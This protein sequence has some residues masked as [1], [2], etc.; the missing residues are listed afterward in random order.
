MLNYQDSHNSRS[1]RRVR[2]GVR[3]GIA[4]AVALLV[5]VGVAWL[6][7]THT[8][9]RAAG[10]GPEQDESGVGLSSCTAEGYTSTTSVL[11][12]GTI[13]FHISSD[14][15]PLDIYIYREG[16]SKEL[17]T[18][19]N[20][21]PAQMFPCQNSQLGC[22]WPIAY[23]LQ[24][25]RDWRS[26]LYAAQLVGPGTVPGEH[27]E[28]M[29]FVVLEDMPGSTARILVQ[30][31]SNTWN[32]Y[33][34]RQGLSF[35]TTPRAMEIS[36]DRPYVRQPYGTGPYHWEVPVVRWLESHGYTAEYCTNVDLHYRPEMLDH[37]PMF[38]SLGHDEY[39]SKEM[40]DNLEAYIGRGGNVAFFSSNTCYWQVRLEDQ[41]RK[42]VCFKDDYQEDPL[43]GVD[44][45][46][47]THY[48]TGYPVNRP[49]NKLT[50]VSYHFG[51]IG[52]GGYRVYHHDHW[53]YEGTGLLDEDVFGEEGEG[54]QAREADGAR[55]RWSGG[56]P[57]PTGEDGTPLNFTILGLASK[58]G[59]GMMGVYQRVG[60]VFTTGSWEWGARGLV[61]GI[62]A[63]ER[64]THNVLSRFTTLEE[65][66]TPTPEE[67]PTPEPVATV[68]TLQQGLDG[69]TGAQDTY[70]HSWYPEETHHQE[71]RMHLR[72]GSVVVPLI[73]YDLAGQVPLGAQVERAT[74]NV[75]AAGSGG[76]WLDADVYKVL[77]EWQASEATWKEARA[78][79][80]WTVWG[81]GGVGA[82]H[83]EALY[84]RERMYT[85]DGWYTFDVTELVQEWVDDPGS[86][87]GVVLRSGSPVAVQYD[88]A[89]S[90][91][92][93]QFYHPKLIIRYV[94]EPT[95]TPTGTP[96]AT[97]TAS[98]TASVTPTLLDTSTPTVTG[99]PTE[100]RTPTASPTWT[101]T[102]T[103]TPTA[104]PTETVTDTP[105]WTATP[106]ATRTP[107]L[108]ITP[109]ASPTATDTPTASPTATAT[110]TP[111]WLPTETA[112]PTAS[113]TITST[114]TATPMAT[115][116]DT[117]TVSPTRIH[118]PTLTVTGPP[119][120]L[121]NYLPIALK[122]GIP[123]A[124]ATPTR[125]G[126]P[127]STVTAMPTATPTL[128]MAPTRTATPSASGTSTVT[129]TST[130]PPTL[131]ATPSPTMT[132]TR[133]ATI[134]PTPTATATSTVTPTWTATPSATGAATVTETSMATVTPSPT[135]T[136]TS[137]S[138]VTLT[139]TPTW[140][141]LPTLTGTPSPTAT[142]TR[143]A[144]ITATGTSTPTP[145]A[146]ATPAVRTF[147]YDLDGY[148]GTED[149]YI[150]ADFRDAN[151]GGYNTMAVHTGSD[152]RNKKTSLIRFELGGY[153]PADAVITR[154]QL[155]LSVVGNGAH[156]MLVKAY[157][158]RRTWLEYEVTWERATNDEAW[159]VPGCSDPSTDR[160]PTAEAFVTLSPTIARYG[161]N[162]TDMVQTW[163][164]HPDRNAGLM[165]E[166]DALGVAVGYTF[167]TREYWDASLRPELVVS[168]IAGGGPLP[169][170][171]PTGSATTGP[172][173]TPTVTPTWSEPLRL[174]TEA[175][176]GTLIA[177]MG[178]TEDAT[179]SGCY[180]V[181]SPQGSDSPC[182]G[183]K[184]IF[185][186]DI[187]RDGNY[188]IYT[189]VK[190]PDENHNS[191]WVSVDDSD[192]YSTWIPPLAGNAF[193]D[194]D[195]WCWDSISD[196]LR[197]LDPLVFWFTQGTHTLRICAR[198][199]DT[200]LDLIEATT[201]FD[202]DT[203]II[204]CDE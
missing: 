98:V 191:F 170:A 53:V 65:N 79:E 78:G 127:S 81:C 92:P 196:G 201:A 192:D 168:Y 9:S 114:P 116:F 82:D 148:T 28:Y 14:C 20:D 176:D 102:A 125:T 24:V 153:L 23:R 83:S 152:D 45:D 95:A 182:E 106:T 158:L 35:Y 40:R 70:L 1:S 156:P 7:S 57:V 41:G 107:T 39:W 110:D 187:P 143:T 123:L 169:T 36:Y 162:I 44:N 48:W 80:E 89:T 105:A 159:A 140:P 183:G 126:T 200:R 202:F 112:L 138:T 122:D 115:A 56:Y 31:S 74:L 149:A 194:T 167:A 197:M 133:T 180:Y 161:F 147:R 188:R 51:G 181:S 55:Y 29:L 113:P 33:T 84:D 18:V 5:T 129:V 103:D 124:A 198:E 131:T 16:A 128:T 12:G 17:I 119:G 204:P 164:S 121:R 134:T 135:A 54:V 59:H 87:K 27:G 6:L 85:A 108:I 43:F 71:W 94:L 150:S 117:P 63:V 177:P 142:E 130:E 60:E 30:W 175:E 139:A 99:T 8:I 88:F 86:N 13:D 173:L 3:T 73:R 37:Y 47:V 171:T 46:R 76:N 64:I 166:A 178:L 145:T 193:C 174:R 32:A 172:T 2:P 136:D 67:T 96:T 19:L 189:R 195:G 21:V 38:I 141:A 155:W 118:T 132:E 165:L 101:P 111:T 34:E 185:S 58:L 68:V 120:L 109:T 4:L 49:E 184:V 72:P 93:T 62:P 137:T 26:G 203:M 97:G 146:T 186:V 25:P 50:G 160:W 90:E 163:I 91:D 10:S 157:H 22:A 77:R 52:A 151:Y 75:Y 104:S 190:A 15:S 144:T 66:P 61:P 179:A 42:I 69:Y 100:T 154:A 199:A 11:Q